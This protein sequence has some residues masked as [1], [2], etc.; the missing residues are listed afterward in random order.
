MEIRK[1]GISWNQVRW[2]GADESLAGSLAQSVRVQLLNCQFERKSPSHAWFQIVDREL[3]KNSAARLAVSRCQFQFVWELSPRYQFKLFEQKNC[4]CCIWKYTGLQYKL[5]Q[6][7]RQLPCWGSCLTL[8]VVTWVEIFGA[9]PQQSTKG[10]VM[11]SLNCFIQSSNVDA[12]HI[13][14]DSN[15]SCCLN[16]GI[17]GMLRILLFCG[18]WLVSPGLTPRDQWRPEER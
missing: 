6:C 4:F 18:K 16:Y 12:G 2:D 13:C 15:H 9:W 17:I 7:E 8:G 14:C 3:S 1:D 11:F 5:R 10:L